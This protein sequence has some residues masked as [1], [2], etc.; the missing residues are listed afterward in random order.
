M[1]KV[2]SKT[3]GQFDKVDE[4]GTKVR[5]KL[6]S[7]VLTTGG[8]TSNMLSHLKRKHS[9]IV[10]TQ[11]NS[12]IS[13]GDN[14][15]SVSTIEQSLSPN[16]KEIDEALT[17]MLA[18]DFQPFS[19]V[20]D[21]GFRNF[22]RHIN[23]NYRIPEKRTIRYEL[24]PKLFNELKAKLKRILSDIDNL[25]LTTDVWTSNSMESYITIT[26][27]FFY[28]DDLKSCVLT[29]TLLTE[30]HTA[31]HLKD[32]VH[33]IFTEWEIRDKV[34][35]ITT[36]NGA[37]I[38]KMVRLLGLR[39]MPCF[40][41][42]LNLV[43]EYSLK[44]PGLIDLIEKCKKIVK[45]FKKSNIATLTLRKEQKERNPNVE[46]LQLIQEVRTR[47]N[48]VY[49]MIKR[50]L[51]LIDSIT[52]AQRKL[53]QAPDIISPEEENILK[54]VVILLDIFEQATEMISGDQYPTSSLIIPIIY[55]LFDNIQSLGPRVSITVGTIFL[56]TLKENMNNHL[57]DYES[58]TVCRI[59]TIL[60]PVFRNSFRHLNNKLAAKEAVKAE[61]NNIIRVRNL[62]QVTDID[63][64]S[65]A[66]TS[67]TGRPDLLGFL[68]KNLNNGGITAATA[69]N[70]IKMY[71]ETQFPHNSHNWDDVVQ[72]W[73]FN[74]HLEPLDE[75]AFKYLAV[76]ATS[77]RSER[78]FSTTGH[79]LNDRRNMLRHDAIDMLCFLNQNQNLLSL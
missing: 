21:K 32:V 60:H 51:K 69:I 44:V 17:L 27:H 78:V 3:R 50:I 79:I 70:L 57:L 28:R 53:P 71:T 72:F 10:S 66:S 9:E 65:I 58:R 74:K 4:S 49:Y 52:A 40:A 56:Q 25:S 77:V 13:S 73:K 23:P 31:D 8:G 68:K 37:N 76:P 34:I 62:P 47:W 46:P 38:V 22:V 39:S 36:D 55:G 6:C 7:A 2:Q 20:D 5:C 26:V 67:D 54:D 45:Y 12:S 41:H 15:D 59:S 30:S 18:T 35:C 24:M 11:T 33:Q 43:V 75:I 63:T 61:I 29:T 64:L 42:T 48:S 19:M 14:N 16:F 1:P